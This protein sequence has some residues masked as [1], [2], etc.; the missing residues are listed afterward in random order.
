MTVQE[1]I[2]ELQ[3]H[4]PAAQVQVSVQEP[5]DDDAETLTDD[6]ATV[7]AETHPGQPDLV[8][9]AGLGVD[10]ESAPIETAPR[11]ATHRNPS[12]DKCRECGRPCPQGRP[13]C[14]D[15]LGR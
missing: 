6:A 2:G 9:I 1:L 13:L 7:T 15:C 14:M 12:D 11:S 10:D 4:N 5:Y 3:K 8:I